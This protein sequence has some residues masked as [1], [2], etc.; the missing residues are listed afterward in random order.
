M[1]SSGQPF[2]MSKL[3]Y[4]YVK[5]LAEPLANRIIARAKT[6]DF[7]KRI[8]CLPPANLYHMYESKVKYR[9]MNIG[10]IRMKSVPKMTE[11]EAIILGGNL[12][13]ECCFYAFASAIALNEVLKH[14]ARE[15]EN[16]ET[17][18][19]ES[20]ELLQNV[21]KLDKIIDNQL[22]DIKNLENIIKLYDK[23]LS[24]LD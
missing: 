21:D 7:F 10:K 19:V 15:R 11:K 18:E 6:D 24:K 2:P 12:F 22:C 8:I 1:S 4:M 13:A 23:T 14:K 16:D 9:V 3:L 20:K 17:I 5:K